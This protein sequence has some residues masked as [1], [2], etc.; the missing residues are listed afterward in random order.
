M[1]NKNS[2]C[3]NCNKKGYFRFYEKSNK[4]KEYN[5]QQSLI[6]YINRAK[7]KIKDLKQKG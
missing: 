1:M 3:P 7:K 5:E 2:I 6:D 4:W